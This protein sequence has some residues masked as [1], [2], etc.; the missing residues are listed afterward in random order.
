VIGDTPAIGFAPLGDK[1]DIQTS[2]PLSNET[3]KQHKPSPNPPDSAVIKRSD[4]GVESKR[5]RK[6]INRNLENAV[7]HYSSSVERLADGSLKI[8][9]SN[10]ISFVP[11]ST[12]FKQAAA[13]SI[14]DKLA[15]VLRNYSGFKVQVVVASA[16]NSNPES[17]DLANL[18]KLRAQAVVKYLISTG[19]PANRTRSAGRISNS[20]IVELFLRPSV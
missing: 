11:S 1:S 15:F 18:S 12:Q 17:S 19:I 9:L 8:I 5:G 14:L 4:S 3:N 6:V 7:R 10:D 16:L 13:G 20:E 2:N